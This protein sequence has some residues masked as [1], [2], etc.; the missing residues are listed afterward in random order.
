MT[1]DFISRVLHPHTGIDRFFFAAGFV[2]G[3]TATLLILGAIIGLFLHPVPRPYAGI[4]EAMSLT[5]LAASALCAGAYVMEWWVSF[6]STN[7]YERFAFYHARLS[8]FSGFF[9]FVEIL[10]LLVPQ[11]F[12]LRRFRRS[13]LAILAIATL[14]SSGIWL[15]K[16]II[17]NTRSSTD[18]LPPSWRAH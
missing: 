15:E 12:W 8:G 14:A 16:L 17:M 1:E 18:Y 11:C 3:L 6:S 13:L 10:C 9:Y 7:R 2:Y 5:L 4:L